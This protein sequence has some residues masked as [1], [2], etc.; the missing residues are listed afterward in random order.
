MWLGALRFLIT[1][2]ASLFA[3]A[4]DIGREVIWLN[5]FGKRF[6]DPDA[7]RPNGAPRRSVV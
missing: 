4:V 5:C 7:G 2:D 3:E 6:A 1:A